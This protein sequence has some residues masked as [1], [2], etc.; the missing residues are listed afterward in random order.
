MD[1]G[2]LIQ[3]ADGG[4]RHLTA[5]ERFGDILHAPNGYAGKV[6]LNERFFHAAFPAAVAFDDGRLK[7]NAFETRHIQC[8][9]AGGRG[10]V[11]AVMTASVALA[12]LAAL[13]LGSLSQLLCLSLQQTVQRFFYAAAN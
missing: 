6:H 10:K 8:N 12:F 5:P 4:G 3:L 11:S 13:V 2:L 1:V 7:R 9:V